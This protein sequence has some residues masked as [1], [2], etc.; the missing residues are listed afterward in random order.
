MSNVPLPNP[1]DTGK[2][3]ALSFKISS[4]DQVAFGWNIGVAF[5]LGKVGRK[6]RAS[7][8]VQNKCS[9]SS[10][11]C[12]G[13]SGGKLRFKVPKYAEDTELLFQIALYLKQGGHLPCL[14]P[15]PCIRGYPCPVHLF[16]INTK[17]LSCIYSSLFGP[18]KIVDNALAD[19]T[20]DGIIRF[21]AGKFSAIK[22]AVRVGMYPKRLHRQD[23]LIWAIKE[24]TSFSSAKEGKKKRQRINVLSLY[25]EKFLQRNGDGIKLEVPNEWKR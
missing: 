15:H 21:S 11:Q 25:E 17:T 5:M 9:L 6:G 22:E 14:F 3:Y 19:K 23:N 20:Q 18:S 4:T 10:Y 16:L 12:N 13:S 2:K 7:E 8:M 1:N 24:S